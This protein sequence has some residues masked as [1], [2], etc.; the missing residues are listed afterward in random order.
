MKLS[1]KYVLREVAGKGVL[2]P[3]RVIDALR[4]SP[5][6]ELSATVKKAVGEMLRYQFSRMVCLPSGAGISG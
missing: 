5:A 1:D 4:K 6:G 2:M 3:E